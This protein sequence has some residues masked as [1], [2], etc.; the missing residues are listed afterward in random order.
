MEHS[1]EETFAHVHFLAQMVACLLRVVRSAKCFLGNI[2][3]SFDPFNFYDAIAARTL[4][5][6]ATLPPEVQRF[7]GFILGPFGATVVGYFILMYFIVR[8]PLAYKERWAYVAIVS[9]VGTWFVLDTTMSLY[10]GALFKVLIVNIPCVIALG[11]PLW[12][13]RK[14]FC[15]QA[16]A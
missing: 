14:E 6:T 1:K 16:A 3:G 10:H 11:L 9:A 13:L 15:D 7:Q 4:Y 5:G 2:Y 12:G 8:Y